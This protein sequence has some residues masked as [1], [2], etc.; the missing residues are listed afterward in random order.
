[1]KISFVIPAYNIENYIS[2]TIHS[3]ISQSNQNFEA[4]IVDDGSTDNTYLIVSDLIRESNLRNFKIIRQENRGVSAARNRGLAEAA[5]DYVLFLDGDDYIEKELVNFAHK[6][7]DEKAYDIICWKFNQVSADEQVIQ[8]FSNAHNYK[9]I[10]NSGPNVLNEIF[11]GKMRILT[12]SAI[13]NKNFLLKNNLVYSEKFYCG[14][15]LEFIYKALIDA[16]DVRFIDET[17]TSYVQRSGSITH[18]YNILKFQ[19]ICALKQVYDYTESKNRDELKD[20]SD[21]MMYR[22]IPDNYF[23]NLKSCVKELRTQG[24]SVKKA[25][26]KIQNDLQK[27]LPEVKEFIDNLFKTYPDNNFQIKI[28]IQLYRISPLFYLKSSE[29]GNA[30]FNK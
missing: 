18:S 21:K 2:K 4:V 16:E 13:F 20:L 6:A 27:N 29:I 30:V 26:T 7:I 14:E 28:M 11:S 5:G 19:S 25:V 3:L 24:Y 12:G 1:M 9:K 8:T 23:F 22:I 17:L 10:L 15:D